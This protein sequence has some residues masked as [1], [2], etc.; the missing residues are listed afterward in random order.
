MAQVSVDVFMQQFLPHKDVPADLQA[1][2]KTFKPECF[3]TTE[4][5]MYAEL[6]KVGTSVFEQAAQR[7]GVPKLVAKD[8]NYWPDPTDKNDYDDAAKPDVTVYPHTEEAKRAYKVKPS[9]QRTNETTVQEGGE[10]GESESDVGFQARTVWSWAYL[11]IEA[12]ATPDY[13]PFALPKAKKTTRKRKTKKGAKKGNKAA[14]GT[15]SDTA[16]SQPAPPTASKTA[17]PAAP[18]PTASP[19]TGT[20]ASDNSTTPSFLHS[21]SEHGKE[22]LGQISRYAAKILRRQ[23]LAHCFTIFVYRNYAW[24]MRWDRA[25]LVISE[26]FDFIQQP[27]LLH[28]FFYLFVC[29]TDVERGCDPTVQP[30]TE[31][32]I[33]RMRAF[34]VRELRHGVAQDQVLKQRRRGTGR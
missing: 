4:H 24:L 6:C 26:P 29:M 15:P 22:T 14:S 1:A 23:F 30:A 16:Q 21:S 20:P 7:E 10:E 5:P 9:R 27:Q 2:V 28:K 3:Q 31:A 8:T 19:T 34:G 13:L 17:S 33:G 32:E 18:A 12:K 11:C 25:G